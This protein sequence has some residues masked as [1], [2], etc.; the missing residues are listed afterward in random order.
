VL[1]QIRGAIVLF[2]DIP[3]SSIPLIVYLNTF[4]KFVKEPAK[5]VRNVTDLLYNHEVR[6]NS[7]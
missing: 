4:V 1:D 3:V 2:E 5:Q 6:K 7:N